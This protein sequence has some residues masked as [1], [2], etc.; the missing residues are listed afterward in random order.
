[1][2]LLISMRFTLLTQYY[3]PE[4][5]APQTR[6]HAFALALRR[7]GHA[8]QVV[9]AMPNYPGAVVL[10]DYRGRVFMRE[11]LD[12]VP[13]IRTWI[14][15]A[16]GR[17]VLKRLANYFSFTFSSLFALARVP[18]ADV[19][20]VESPPLFLGLSAWLMATL[21]RQK[22]CVNISD[23]WPDSVVALGIMREGGFVR[24][25]RWLEK[26]LY[27]RAW[28]V[29]GVTDGIVKT[30][31]SGKSV[32]RA[33]VRF[34][35]NGVDLQHFAPAPPNLELAHQ[36]GLANKKVFAYT[37]LHGYAQGLDVIL[38]SA[39]H[40]RCRSDI[41]F[42]FVGEGPEKARLIALSCELRLT[43]IVFLEAQPLE[44]MPAL[45]ALTTACI[46]PLLK[47]PLFRDARPSK[48]FPPLGCA[49][50]VIFSGEGEAAR[51]ITE[52]KC[53][54]VTPP[55]DARTLAQAV[56][57]LADNPDLARAMG[58]NGRTYAEQNY[59]WDSIVAKWLNEL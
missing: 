53:G 46:V 34:L 50:P 31:Y 37:G 8:V 33:K 25:A 29:C 13:V 20:F 16:T 59:G 42:L 35:P 18:S 3:P 5:G 12:G 52:G 49:K 45:I 55:E 38:Q 21:R 30:L 19:L 4:V 51:L 24:L 58:E 56:E 6:L 15:P 54:I 26:W 57:Q 7:Q 36:L 17:N 14:Y 48:L 2:Q 1:M 43:N 47:H 23:L 41:V 44:K 27:D 39:A 28:R 10:P 32:P 22:L 9:T 11:V 40:L